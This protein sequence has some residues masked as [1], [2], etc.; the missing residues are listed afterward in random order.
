MLLDDTGKGTG[1]LPGFS[2]DRA[3]V[4]KDPIDLEQIQFLL[5]HASVQRRVRYI[6]CNLKL[7]NSANG[8]LE[9]SVA[10]EKC[11]KPVAEPSYIAFPT[12]CA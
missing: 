4:D 6:G 12:Y 2:R 11:L 1:F 10:R 5:G 7:Q 9:I 8:R 3:A